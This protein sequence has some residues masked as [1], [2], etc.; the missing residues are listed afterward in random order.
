[1]GTHSTRA[2]EMS[3]LQPMFEA[4]SMTIE[5]EPKR[6]RDARE[7]AHDAAAAAGLHEADCYQVRL[8]MSE[9]VANAIQHG[10]YSPTDCIRLGAF[11][12]DGALVFEIRDT[13][14]FDAPLVRPT[15]ED[16]SGRGL[17]LLALMM[18]E[19]QITATG[20]GSLLRFSKKLA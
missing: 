17:E 1:M 5:A 18:D 9:A 15:L 11:E 13:G 12:D 3:P 16:E 20:D 7:W 6:L 19:V 8:A 2:H 14:I 10:S 4:R